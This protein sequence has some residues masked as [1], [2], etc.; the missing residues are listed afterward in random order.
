VNS[1]GIRIKQG[2]LDAAETILRGVLDVVPE[3]SPER[4]R[5]L[6]QLARMHDAR[7]DH[8]QA[9]KELDES[10]ELAQ[11]YLGPLHP[12]VA[13]IRNNRGTTLFYLGRYDESIAEFE[14]V[15]RIK[16][17]AFGPDHPSVAT[18]L[19]NLANLLDEQKRFDEAVEVL[20]RARAISLATRGDH[21]EH[22]EVLYAL[23]NV[24]KHARRTDDA[25]RYFRQAYDHHR[26]RATPGDPTTAFMALALAELLVYQTEPGDPMFE[27][28]RG[29]LEKAAA[30]LEGKVRPAVL[31]RAAMLQSQ[32]AEQAKDLA[33]ARAHIEHALQL[34][35][36]TPGP[37]GEEMRKDIGAFAKRLGGG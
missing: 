21:A 14:E 26:A 24:A 12:T 28:G 1:A 15:V 27:E 7:G 30:D 20:E 35:Q 19:Q 8:A 37:E 25:R 2:D 3:D 4:F 10:V 9:L 32:V 22:A 13:S 5:A 18:S 23:G 33:R 16:E 31:A 17:A 6:Q 36:D 11:R 29:L 34:A